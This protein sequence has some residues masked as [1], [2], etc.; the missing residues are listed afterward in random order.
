MKRS[1]CMPEEVFV[2]AGS[3]AMD[4]YFSWIGNTSHPAEWNLDDDDDVAREGRELY[5]GGI[6]VYEEGQDWF[7]S[8]DDAIDFDCRLEGN[9]RIIDPEFFADRIREELESRGIDPWQM[10]AVD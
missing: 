10:S 6:A 7:R 3:C 4:C 2:E 9:L 5:E 8:E 1:A